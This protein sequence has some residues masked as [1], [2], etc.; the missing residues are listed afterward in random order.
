MYNNK[1]VVRFAKGV[2]AQIQKVWE[3]RVVAIFYKNSNL[4]REKR[5]MCNVNNIYNARLWLHRLANAARG[6]LT[7]LDPRLDP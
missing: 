2:T 3:A 7:W 1:V 6:W 5:R 4:K